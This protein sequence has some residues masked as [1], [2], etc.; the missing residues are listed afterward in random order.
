MLKVDS[1]EN[2]AFPLPF[3]QGRKSSLFPSLLPH[4]ILGRK[5]INTTAASRRQPFPKREAPRKGHSTRQQHQ[6]EGR[7]PQ[8]KHQEGRPTRQQ[9]QGEGHSQQENHQEEIRP[10]CY[11]H[12]GKGCL[13]SEKRKGESSPPKR[14]IK[15]KSVPNSSRT[16]EKAVHSGS[17]IKEKGVILKK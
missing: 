2:Q 8:Q 3:P 12:K 7:L 14:G 10:P 17:I 11:Q 1:E 5:L 15:E 4:L 6:G 9:H 16:R 13:P